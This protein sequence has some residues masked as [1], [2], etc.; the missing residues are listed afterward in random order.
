MERQLIIWQAHEGNVSGANIAMLEYIDA[1]KY[2][3]NFHVILP[4][5]GTMCNALKIRSVPYSLI[6]Q[7]NWI[8][9]KFNSIRERLKYFIRTKVAL[10]KTVS[11]I[12]KYK[13]VFLF[14]NTQAPFVGAKAAFIAKCQHVWWIHEFG[15]EDFGFSIGLG[16]R[17]SAYELIQKWSI[18]IIC[19]SYAVA[20]KFR[21]LMPQA[22]IKVN[23]QPVSWNPVSRRIS[24]KGKYLMFGQLTPAKGHLEVIEAMRQC[25]ISGKKISSLYIIGPCHDKEYL[26]NLIHSIEEAGLKEWITIDVGFFEKESILPQFEVLLLPSRSE[27]FGRVIIEASK[28]GLR[29]VVKNVGGAKEIVTLSNCILYNNST[30]LEAILSGEINLPNDDALIIYNEKEEIGKLKHYLSEIMVR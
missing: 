14:T 19:N 16:H 23:Y 3:Y 21:Y 6:P 7:Y 24:T 8:G 26:K 5:E 9:T 17:K 27:A 13:P 29:V 28:A 22:N 30:E 11:L 12:R 1:L 20:E 18:L 2:D 10:Q 15:E 25:L 4:H